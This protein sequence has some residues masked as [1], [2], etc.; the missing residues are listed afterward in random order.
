MTTCL[1]QNRRFKRVV[2]PKGKGH[3]FYVIN[4]ITQTYSVSIGSNRL[5]E[6]VVIGYQSNWIVFEL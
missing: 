5:F 2:T 4:K 3:Q 1:T 6:L